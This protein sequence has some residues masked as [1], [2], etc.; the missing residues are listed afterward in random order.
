M[1]RSSRTRNLLLLVITSLLSLLIIDVF[2]RIR[3]PIP[4]RGHGV[5]AAYPGS[6]LDL[7]MGPDHFR[8]TH[9]YNRFGFRGDD[10]RIER[11]TAHRIVC[12]G[13]SYTEGVGA[14]EERT[15]PSLLAGELS[16]TGTDVINL[17]DAG[18][19]LA[20]YAN[21]ISEVATLL[22][23]TDVILCINTF[24]MRLGPSMPRKLREPE[25]FADPFRENRAA[26]GRPF[27]VL[28]PGLTYL[29]DRMR[30]MWP[31]QAGM[32]WNAYDEHMTQAAARELSEIHHVPIEEG[33]RVVRERMK[34][35]ADG[36]LEAARQREFN[37]SIV[38]STLVYPY[39][40]Y[41]ARLRDWGI[42]AES[43]EAGMRKWLQWYA[44]T[45]EEKGARPW[46]LYFPEASL[47]SDGSWGP[48]RDELYAQVERRVGD[49]S[50]R[51]LLQRLCGEQGIRFIDPTAA[52]TTHADEQLY[53]RYD[54]HPTGRAY[55]VVAGVVAQT[56]RPS[57]GQ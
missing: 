1:T 28:L 44:S 25:S 53:F 54:P 56:V 3:Y 7:V 15:W 18:S 20:R 40:T 55:E 47:I 43:M 46:L 48:L 33:E 57:L 45:C 26:W 36:I 31:R 50:V 38:Q 34:G 14:V 4:I 29:M 24:D 13:D 21:I 8:T 6:T 5:W 2:A 17:G 30:G 37:P 16:G 12:V 41:E 23:P 52:L 51:D 35:F 19:G 42:P 39:W 49:T 27:A 11:T 9:R 32:Y 22:H 10:F